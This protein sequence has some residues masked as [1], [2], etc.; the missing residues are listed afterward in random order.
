[1]ETTVRIPNAEKWTK[2]LVSEYLDLM[3]KDAVNED[4]DY[5]GIGLIRQGLYIQI[6]AYWKKKFED[7][8][9]IMEVMMLIESI[10][11]ARLVRGALRKEIAPAFAIFLLRNNHH[12]GARSQGDKQE[13]STMPSLHLKADH[14]WLGE[15]S[16]P[17]DISKY[18]AAAS[19]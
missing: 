12:W 13:T 2:G 17:I 14:V 3:R 4:V 16:V 10:F 5:L 1:M 11:E 7:D 6:W 8:D 19:A 18:L 15:G 9:D